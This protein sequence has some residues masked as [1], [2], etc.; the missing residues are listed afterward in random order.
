MVKKMNIGGHYLWLLWVTLYFSVASTA[1]HA[2]VISSIS[3]L[4]KISKHSDVDVP[5][6]ALKL[7]EGISNEY[8]SVIRPDI[9]G[10]WQIKQSDGSVF[11]LPDSMNLGFLPIPPRAL[12][13]SVHDLPKDFTLFEKLPPRLPVFVQSDSKKLFELKRPTQR[14]K[15][16]HIDSHSVSVPVKD[17]NALQ[18]AIWH[19]QRPLMDLSSHMLVLDEQSDKL[20][21]TKQNQQT[22]YFEARVVGVSNLLQALPTMKYETVVLVGNV[23]K[24]IIKR[25]PTDS[26][27]ISLNALKR[28][29]KEHDIN[30]V[31][32]NS[33]NTD[34]AI[35]VIVEH[36][37]QNTFPEIGLTTSEFF[38]QFAR[39]KHEILELTVKSSGESQT[40]VQLHGRRG[41]IE[42]SNIEKS[43]GSLAVAE[44]ADH[45]L[46][47][48]ISLY[49]PDEVRSEELGQRIFPFVHSNVQFYLIISSILGLITLG[50]SWG[51]WTRTWSL[52]RPVGFVQ[53]GVYFIIWPVHKLL[54][55]LVFIPVLGFF[56][57]A[58]VVL[59]TT[60]RIVYW[61]SIKPLLWLYHKKI[62]RRA[63][64]DS[65][66]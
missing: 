15:H 29:A 3:K 62:E 33:A 56:S 36:F 39:S 64:V 16:W 20:L 2:S 61:I 42:P 43:E 46:V 31:I 18:A 11:A 37:K 13:M 59:K 60:W 38:D 34:K 40:L 27:S 19:L 63:L 24:G 4:S 14:D 41:F 66:D 23:Q 6:Q 58:F 44:V 65:K 47:K 30:L 35:K 7:P 49:H 21:S 25:R 9:N 32:I 1:C 54:F 57:F 12:V 28:A 26:D 55:L 8:V 10:H 17:A 53:W 22:E 52:T 45:T 48:G 5:I 50:T 51:F